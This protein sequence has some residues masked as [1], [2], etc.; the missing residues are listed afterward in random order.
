MHQIRKSPVL[1]VAYARHRIMEEVTRGDDEHSVRCATRA[2]KCKGN[3]QHKRSRPSLVVSLC[4][5]QHC[6]CASMR[7]ERND[8]WKSQQHV[9]SRPD[10]YNR[11][12]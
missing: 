4:R 1:I 3:L 5:L 12:L 6:S 2:A 8:V 9:A 10:L 7:G 11:S